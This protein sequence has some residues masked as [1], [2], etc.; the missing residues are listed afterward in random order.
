M[1]RPSITAEARSNFRIPVDSSIAGRRACCG[2]AMP[3]ES[4]SSS[5]LL[6]C[7]RLFS[8]ST[9]WLPGKKNE[10]SSE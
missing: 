6:H 3:P 10:R 9:L 4:D 2:I 8:S 5:M 7:N 1:T